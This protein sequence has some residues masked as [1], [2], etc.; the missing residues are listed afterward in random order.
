VLIDQPALGPGSAHACDP[1]THTVRNT[2]NTLSVFVALYMRTLIYNAY[3]YIYTLS[4][5]INV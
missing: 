3:I 1:P 4:L 2:N 5:Y